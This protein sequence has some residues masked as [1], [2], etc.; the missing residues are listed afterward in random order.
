VSEQSGE[1]KL[2]I[3][4]VLFIDIVGYSKLL[5]TEQSNQI[6]TL[7]EIVRGT[8][9]VRL[10]EAEGKLLRLP[11]GD[12]GALVFRNNLEAPVLCALEIAK[13]L[14]SHPEIRVRMGVH[15]GPV[16][17]VTDLNEQ[18]NVAGAGINVAQRVM[19]CGDAGHILLSK[20]VADD[21]E[22]YPQWRFRLQELGDCEVKHGVRVSL[23]NLYTDEAGNSAVPGKL[24]EARK[25]LPSR[26]RLTTP[27]L[28][29]A[30]LGALI[31]LGVPALI[32]TP[33]IL[34]SLSSTPKPGATQAAEAAI[35]PDKSIAVLPF[36]NL[37]DD[38]SNTYF[39]DGIQDEILTRLAGIADLKVISR[40]STA[41]YK[42]KPEDLKT[43]SQQ[44][45]VATVLEGTVQRAADK[46][47]VNV[48]LIDARADS[49]LWAKSY[50]RDFKDVFAV[51]S[52]VSQEIAD[53]L[54]AKLSPKEANNLAVVPTTN[55]EAY[56]LFL[57]GEYAQHAAESSLKAEGFDQAAALYEQAI[58][59]DSN[60][61]LAIA[62]WVESRSYR[63]HFGDSLSDVET[64]KVR[65][66]AEHAVT[67]APDIAETHIALGLFYYFCV[68][69][70][71]RA[72]TEFQRALVSEPNNVRA[73][74]FLAGIHARQGQF[75]RGFSELKKCEEL[76]PRDPAISD[77][78]GAYYL[79][80]RMWEEAKHA[81]LHSL[82]LDPRN[83]AGMHIVFFSYLNG[84]G[85]IREAT[86][87]LKTFEPDTGSW[88]F[89]PGGYI[90]IINLDA[91]LSV[92]AR[93]FGNAFKAWGSESS[94]PSANRLRL[95]ARAVIHVFAG[96]AADAQLEI[97]KARVLVEAKLREQPDDADSII[98]LS[99]INLAM[100]RDAEAIKLA[101]KAAASVPLEKDALAG[102]FCL[103]ALAEI[104]ARAGQPAEAVKTLQ[105][106][107]SI[108][109]GQTSAIQRLK[110]D[111]V[112]D[113]IRNDPG[114]QQ[115]LAGKEQIGP[116]K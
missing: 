51:E 35:V 65:K 28:L 110:I 94:D 98:Q 17:E 100:K 111:P 84:T 45:G 96:D 66:A 114:F 44:L 9:Q 73:L 7:K 81:G 76:D 13:A 105:R 67:L 62:R 19:D 97:E 24:A 40:T 1:V 26:K 20:R 10:A 31:C 90:A 59:R 8:E 93:D 58:A 68:F 46:V 52:E 109:A 77:N 82:A 71:D 2:E 33:A 102:A 78:I 55:P 37:S 48:Q 6:Q 116:N 99:W 89:L 74:K 23:V 53:A 38:K 64:G 63:M 60:F 11:T 18:S 3:G 88:G 29:F 95:S 27:Q 34:K 22:Q 104:Q 115:L 70:Y 113:P 92:V 86:R 32:F 49:H 80:V 103:G 112:W 83:V 41:K 101:N 47:R 87:I 39:A 14:K 5:I 42:S 15:S 43:V 106:L 79:N 91:Y 25:E 69:Q 50:D 36:E 21:L 75:E 57:K 12:G 85:N 16:N 30:T 4:H 107:L 56:D 54:Q 72:L 61:A 108:P